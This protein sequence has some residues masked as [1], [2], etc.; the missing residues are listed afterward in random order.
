LYE[1]KS[2]GRSDSTTRTADQMQIANFWKDAGGTTYA[3]GHWN[4]IATAVSVNEGLDLVQNARLFA[5]L[6]MAT[7]DALIDA[8]DAKFDYNFWRPI[9]AIRYSGDSGLNPATESDA[10][11]TPLIGTPNFPSYTSAHSTVSSA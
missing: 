3:F 6:N 8:W 4:E 7:A 10:T 2:L 1:V 11:W 5:L 9:T